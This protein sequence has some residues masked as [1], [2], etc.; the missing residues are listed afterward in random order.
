MGGTAGAPLSLGRPPLGPFPLPLSDSWGEEEGLLAK[1]HP[2]FLLFPTKPCPYSL[3]LSPFFYLAPTP[4]CKLHQTPCPFT[5]KP[6]AILVKP[7][8]Y[9][10]IISRSFHFKINY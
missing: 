7:P 9:I 10:N 6:E 8:L 3:S 1:N 2:T 5:K 4:L